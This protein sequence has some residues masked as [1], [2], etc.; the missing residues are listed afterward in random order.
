MISIGLMR[1][2]IGSMKS[3]CDQ[4]LRREVAETLNVVFMIVQYLRT[5]I[6]YS[7]QL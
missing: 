6:P 3:Y 2:K 5:G 4:V 1:P 7:I